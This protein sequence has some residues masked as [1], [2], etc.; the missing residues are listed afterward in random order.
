MGNQTARRGNVFGIVGCSLGIGT[1]LI[2]FSVKLSIA[3][4]APILAA[5]AAGAVVGSSIARSVAFTSLPELVAAFHSFVGIAAVMVSLAS[6]MNG[7]IL[8][9]TDAHALDAMHL[10][11]IY[12]GTF[13]GGITFTGSLVAFGKLRNL[14]SSAALTFPGLQHVNVALFG[15]NAAGMAAFMTWPLDMGTGLSL[16]GLNATLSFIQ[17]YLL[18]A[19]IGGADVPVAITVLNSYS[20][21]ALAAE[22]FMLDN[23]LALLSVLWLVLRVLSS[24]TSCASR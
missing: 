2:D 21:W 1:M 12:I 24:P 4:F 11:S 14:L 22:G 20:G 13:L 3:Q 17:G 7:V 23:T 10:G 15:A 18:T 16:I 6:F 19:A 9:P 5:V 8:P